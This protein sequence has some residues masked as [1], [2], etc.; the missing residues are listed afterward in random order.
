MVR[1]GVCRVCHGGGQTFIDETYRT[2][3][4][5]QHT[6]MIGSSLGGNITQFIGLEYQDQIGCL[7][8]FHLPNWLHQEAFNRL[9]R[10]QETIV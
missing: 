6:A 5:R 2:K 7:G 10:T 4:D 8:S 1:C 3:S 9:Y